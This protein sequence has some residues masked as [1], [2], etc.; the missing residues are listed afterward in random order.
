[1]GA[2]LSWRASRRVTF[3]V[4]AGALTDGRLKPSGGASQSLRPGPFGG[5][6]AAFRLLEGGP[7]KPFATG[8]VS[9]SCLS[10]RAFA[11][12]GSSAPYF[13][14]DFKA[15][16]IVGLTFWRW[17][18][19]YVGAAIFGGPVL[20]GAGPTQTLGNDTHHYEVLLGLSAALPRGF[21]LFVE[22]SPLGERALSAGVGYAL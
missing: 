15:S 12:D 1:V 11:S 16:G 4:S 21:D 6:T 3:A 13:A 18:S 22:G 10:S 17:L 19:P 9:A 2:G 5:V 14:A 20:W 7:S 8:G